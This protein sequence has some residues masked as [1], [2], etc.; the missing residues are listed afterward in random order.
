MTQA[1]RVTVILALIAMM[2][3]LLLGCAGGNK[4][5][6]STG[7]NESPAADASAKNTGNAAEDA[8]RSYTDYR[9]HVVNIPAAPKRVIFAGETMGD[10]LELGIEPVGVF[11][12]SLSGTLYKNEWP[13]VEDIG[14]PLNLEKATSLNPDLIIIANTD[15]E[16]FASIAKVA[17]A[18][19][20]DTFATIED[21][22]TE[23]GDIFGKQQEAADWLTA[24][25][26]KA[27]AMWKGLY[28]SELKPGETA[29][30]FTYYPGERLFVMAAAG[31][32]QLLYS[33]GGLKPTPAIQEVLDAGEG[34]RQISLEGLM[35][36]AGDRIFILNPV[37][38]EAKKSTQAMLESSI[39]KGLPAVKNGHVYFLEIQESDSDAFTR[40]RMLD[41]LPKLLGSK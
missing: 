41:E 28:Q 4:E 19:M 27:E 30:V 3:V 25:H 36:L 17:P 18:I 20:F 1:R 10:L 6:G 26:D 16:A 39:W 29:S 38:E 40:L 9:N 21:R 12:S 23:L 5:G 14:F 35:E 37:P 15:E 13:N 31:L 22:M 32:P 33:E 2:G 24:Y 11:G 8:V 7:N 34:F